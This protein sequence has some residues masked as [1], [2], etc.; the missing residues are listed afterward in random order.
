MC[1]NFKRDRGYI[2]QRGS[3]VL[4]RIYRVDLGCVKWKKKMNK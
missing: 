1:V 2:E 4:R 3:V